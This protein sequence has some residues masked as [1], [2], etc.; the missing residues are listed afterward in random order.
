M[1]SL[2]IFLVFITQ[3]QAYQ[4]IVLVTAPDFNSSK[5]Q[6]QLYEANDSTFYAVGDPIAVNLGR[7][8]LGWDNSPLPFAVNENDPQKH[9]G[10]GRA[11]SGIFELKK[12]FTSEAL[13]QT[14]IPYIRTTPNLICVDDTASPFYNQLVLV[15]DKVTTKSF[16]WMQRDDGLYKFGILIDNNPNNTP[17][18]GSCVFIHIERGANSPTSGC[19]SMGKEDLQTLIEWLKPDANPL[20]IQIPKEYCSKVVKQYPG[21]EYH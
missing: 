3:L 2:L 17:G 18:R 14:S 13:L 11:P 1:R 9:E 19:T 7:S 16:E 4:Q 12:I 8:G 21:I 15:D 6:M 20:L 5:A 10:D